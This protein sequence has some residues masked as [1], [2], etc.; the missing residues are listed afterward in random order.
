MPSLSK[1][2]HLYKPKLLRSNPAVALYA[3]N[4][5]DEDDTDFDDEGILTGYRSPKLQK[6]KSSNDNNEELSDYSFEPTLI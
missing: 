1:A 5:S 6:S 4:D 2:R 3:L